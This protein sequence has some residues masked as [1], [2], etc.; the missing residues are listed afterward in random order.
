MNRTEFVALIAVVSAVSL[1]SA[2]SP[3]VLPAHCAQT[4][5]GGP[6]RPAGGGPQVKDPGKVQ[7]GD[8]VKLYFTASDEKGEI[9][10]TTDAKVVNDPNLRKASGFIAP[11]AYV[12]EDVWVGH[13]ASIPGLGE[14]VVGMKAGEKKRV[15]LQPDKAYG[16]IDPAKR[17]E[18]PCVRTMPKKIQISAQDYVGNFHSFPI[19]GKEVAVTPYFKAAVVE[20]SEEFAVLDCD[21]GDGE[22]FEE[23]FGT[24]ET[25]VD[26]QNISMTLTP[27]LGSNYPMEGGQQGKIVATDGASF[28]VDSNNPLAGM[29]ITVDLEIAAVTRAAQLDSFQIKWVE[30]YDKGIAMAREEQKPAVLVLYADWCAFCKRLFGETLQDPRVRA[31]KDRFVWIKVNSDAN[32]KFKEQFAQ[33]SFPLIVILNR[34]GEPLDR[35]DGFRTAVTFRDE[36]VKMSK[37][38]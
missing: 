14:A 21:V 12:A 4:D 1:F 10:R 29:P 7:E 38:L 24:V 19:V 8:L 25:K 35:L 3:A 33:K 11:V 37:P 15:V 13:P 23:S 5:K 2:Y 32:V 22:R 36:L 20:I 27:R 9:V 26:G 17:K 16:P 31:F 30:D 34:K 18:M 6:A 28:T